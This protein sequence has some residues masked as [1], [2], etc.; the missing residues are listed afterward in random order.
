MRLRVLAR[1]HLGHYRGVAALLLAGCTATAPAPAARTAV[2]PTLEQIFLDGRLAGSEPEVIALAPGGAHVLLRWSALH[3]ESSTVDR[4]AHLASTRG[5]AN[6]APVR[7][8]E[9]LGIPLESRLL[10]DWS[11]DGRALVCAADERVWL[12]DPAALLG[13]EAP[14][15][16]SIAWP[17]P[18]P[19]AIDELDCAPDGN[20]AWITAGGELWELALAPPWTPRL[21][22]AALAA[23]AGE[24]AWSDDRRVAFDARGRIVS[25]AG[26]AGAPAAHVAHLGADG[27]LAAA[28]ALEGFDAEPAWERVRLSPDGRYVSAWRAERDAPRS[29]ALVPDY[30]SERV[31]VSD[32]R[33]DSSDDRAPR[34][35]LGVWSTQDGALAEIALPGCSATPGAAD[36]ER[37]WLDDLG[38]SRS[39]PGARGEPGAPARLAFQRTSADW[40]RRELWCWDAAGAR[41][42]CAEVDPNWVD[43]PAG[44]A[45]WSA[46]GARLLVASECFPGATTPGRAQLFAVDP[47]N[48]SL[49]Q[50]SQAEGELRSFREGPDGG[51]AFAASGAD[52]ALCA[53]WWLDPAWRG[54]SGIPAAARLE[55][56]EGWALPSALAPG[57]VTLARSATLGRP[58]EL[59][60]AAPGAPSSIVAAPRGAPGARADVVI[61]E[62]VR[63]R[64]AD[65]TLV[66][67]HVFLPPDASLEHPP[68]AP[69]PVVVFVH[70]AGD[71]QNV[72][73]SLSAY[74]VNFLFHGRLARQGVA[75]VDCDYRGSAGY[76]ARFRGEVRG[77]LARLALADIDA[78]LDELAARGLVDRARAAL[79][80]GSYGGFLTI[81]ALAL[82]PGRWRAG[83]ALRSVTDWRAYHPGY[84]QPRLGR[85]SLEPEAYA[86]S[87]PIDHAAAIR[88]PLLLLHGMQDSNVFVQDSLRLVEVLI[89]AGA[90]FELMVYPSQGHAFEDGRAWLDEYRRIEDFLLRHLAA[91]P[92]AP[93]A[94]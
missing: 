80:G 54:S 17:A 9:L 32:A 39:A 28:V 84:V 94:R 52:P 83:A 14:L 81:M 46:D 58:A 89:H 71:L 41:L 3:L 75:V 90:P 33:A 18:A 78:V 55:L 23:A 77:D 13:G 59:R 43:E 12:A 87:S 34:W 85:P 21:H 16:L 5:V 93:R 57:G 30:L 64:A 10:L 49:R 66:S 22:S 11:P 61:P 51:L 65:G 45:R 88:D 92:P 1:S 2:R 56:P 74:P 27:E 69:L 36:A 50:L 4:A 73:A 24:L 82:E 20:A 53:L 15:P 91:Q 63:V 47:S 26:E 86:R 48:G 60:L 8:A 68:A 67:A 42:L 40:R 37:W 6:G 35:T 25:G 29:P 79:Y 62:R 19:A 44:P 76:G 72:R 38:W 31:T 7:L 70:G